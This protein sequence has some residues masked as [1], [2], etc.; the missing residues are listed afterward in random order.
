VTTFRSN[1]SKPGSAV[2]VPGASGEWFCRG[3]GELVGGREMNREGAEGAEFFVG[4]GI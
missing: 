3:L 2:F 4:G 1:P